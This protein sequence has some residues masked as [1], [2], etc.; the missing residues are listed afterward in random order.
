MKL[1]R[2]QMLEKVSQLFGVAEVCQVTRTELENAIE[3]D[4]LESMRRDGGRFFGGH[5]QADFAF[6]QGAISMRMRITVKTMWVAF[7]L[8]REI[9]AQPLP[10]VYSDCAEAP[11]GTERTPV[12]YRRANV[13]GAEGIPCRVQMAIMWPTR[14]HLG[15]KA[16]A[17]WA[18]QDQ[19]LALLKDGGGLWPS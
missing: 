13:L 11:P 15:A 1:T 14:S 5:S 17:P 3:Q 9:D 2:S 10:T 16:F 7:R 4:L 19:I 6:V 12:M 8:V 18:P